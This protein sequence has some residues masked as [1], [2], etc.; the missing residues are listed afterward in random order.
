MANAYLYVVKKTSKK[1]RKYLK[2]L[3]DDNYSIKLQ[4]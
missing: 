4:T 1:L 3:T 2:S